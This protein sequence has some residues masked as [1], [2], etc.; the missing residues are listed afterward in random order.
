VRLENVQRRGDERLTG[1]KGCGGGAEGTAALG[2]DGGDT[3]RVRAAVHQPVY[4]HWT[5]GGG[6]LQIRNAEQP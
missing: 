5:A 4:D 3:C 6:N 2:V 1:G